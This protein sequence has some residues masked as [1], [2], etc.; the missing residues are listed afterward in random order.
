MRR[1]KEDELERPVVKGQLAEIADEVG[2]AFPAWTP[3]IG[4]GWSLALVHIDGEWMFLVPPPHSATAA[5]V[6][7]LWRRR[8]SGNM[9]VAIRGPTQ[10]AHDR[11]TP[12]RRSI[13]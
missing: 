3:R 8:T 12:N 9:R 6:E 2:R 10:T 13:P 7:D 11:P 1:I 4:T 5:S